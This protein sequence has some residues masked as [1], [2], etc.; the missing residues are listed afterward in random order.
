MA[1]AYLD[2]SSAAVMTVMVLAALGL[3]AALQFLFFD[4]RI[5][6]R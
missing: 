1:F 5:H 4:R 2:Q 3:I 6:Y